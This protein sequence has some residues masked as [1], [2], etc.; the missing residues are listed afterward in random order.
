VSRD[1]YVKNAVYLAIVFP[2]AWALAR[3]LYGRR[4]L[5]A[6][7]QPHSV[8]AGQRAQLDEVAQLVRQP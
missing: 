2:I 3:D 8:A 4:V 1:A 6:E 7:V 5:I